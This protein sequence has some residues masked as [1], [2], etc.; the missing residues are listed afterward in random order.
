MEAS[1]LCTLCSAFFDFT[2]ALCCM[3]LFILYLII[4]HLFLLKKLV[5]STFKVYLCFFM[6]LSLSF[7]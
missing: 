4:L 7:R 1:S 3:L 2:K 6:F 5:H